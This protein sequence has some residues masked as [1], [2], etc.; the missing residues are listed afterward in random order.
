M[1]GLH[2][3]RD[4]A[5]PA[6]LAGYYEPSAVFLLG[7]ATQLGTGADAA[8]ALVDRGGAAVVEARTLGDFDAQL[9]RR[10][11]SAKAVAVIDGFNYSKGKRARLTVFRRADEGPDP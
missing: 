5:P 11:A 6:A 8:D 9:S 1:A 3:L 2:P 7:T 10:G 4:N